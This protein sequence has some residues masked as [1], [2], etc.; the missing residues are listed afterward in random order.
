MKTNRRFTRALAA[1]VMVLGTIGMASPA[2]AAAADLEILQSY[3]GKWTGRGSASFSESGNEET[4]VCKLGVERSSD[5][6]INFN[7]R[8]ALAGGTLS[9]AG[10]MA[11]IVDKRRFEA[12]L[13]S[14]TSYSGVAV[15]R[16]SGKS[17]RFNMRERDPDTGA[18]LEINAGLALKNDVIT[19]TFSVTDKSS[20]A[21]TSAVVPMKR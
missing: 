19:V 12:V 15:G 2:L 21:R 10:T 20:G 14:N 9:I 17:L 4:V 18:S 6:K 13:S 8:C 16:R 7:G 11:Y 3:V 5:T 1:L